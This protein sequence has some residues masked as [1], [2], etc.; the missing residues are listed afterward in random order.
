VYLNFITYLNEYW[1]TQMRLSQNELDKI[2]EDHKVYLSSYGAS[3]V[4][5][6]LQNVDLS[7]LDL[8]YANLRSADL[9]SAN[10]SSANLRSANLSSANL[11]YANLSSADLSSANLS[12]ANLRSANL[13]SAN[14]RYANLSSADL[15]SAN[16]SSA[17]LRYANL[18]SADLRY[19]NLSSADLSYAN[20]SSANLPEN[21][22]IITG[23]HYDITICNGE[24]VRA[25]CQNHTVEG[26]FNM[27]RE[28]VINMDGR[29]SLRYYPR[30]L[31]IIDLF[32]PASE[33]RIR[34]E[35]LL[36]TEAEAV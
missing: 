23:E 32:I 22:F 25:G 35:W 17:N 33:K 3:G 2:L 19:A 15:S 27:T 16:L 9:S 28:E 30:L 36:N 12:S 29:T 26:W 5:A 11:R 24:Y 1:R 34:P 20:L 6:N 21:T 13:S 14:L 10:L 18:S 8:S 7:G 31:D 4:E